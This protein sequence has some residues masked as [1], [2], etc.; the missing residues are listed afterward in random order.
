MNA[1][2]MSNGLMDCSL[3][4][5][6]SRS[7]GMTQAEL[8][9]GAIRLADKEPSLFR[10][11]LY[12]TGTLEYFGVIGSWTQ[13]GQRKIYWDGQSYLIIPDMFS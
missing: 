12:S 1:T 7:G 8:E 9:T 2:R 4:L 10:S 13:S 5:L 11:R 6:A 3:D